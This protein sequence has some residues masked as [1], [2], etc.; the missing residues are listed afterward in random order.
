[1]VDAE[2]LFL[3]DNEQAEI[4]EMDILGQ[5][6][7]RANNNIDFT[8]GRPGDGLLLQSIAGKPA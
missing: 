5:Q 3:V 8:R 2:A 4:L 1:V 6:A 7:M